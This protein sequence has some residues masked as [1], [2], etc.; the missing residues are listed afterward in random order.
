MSEKSQRNFREE[1]EKR[2]RNAVWSKV[3]GQRDMCV[4][5]WTQKVGKA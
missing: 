3:M 5:V 4:C 1:S 2:Q